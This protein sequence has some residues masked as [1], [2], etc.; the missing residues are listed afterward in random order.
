MSFKRS[1]VSNQI[2]AIYETTTSQFSFNVGGGGG[3]F[4]TD[5]EGA[6]KWIRG[7]GYLQGGKGG[8]GKGGFGG[9]GGFRGGKPGAGGGGGYSGGNG[10][11]NEQFSCG[12]GGG[13]FNNGTNQQNECCFNRC[14]HGRVIITFLQ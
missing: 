2:G 4:Y 10:G 13:S 7:E 12:G 14:G 3:G 11:A 1:Q 9:G 8:N 5:G 6:P